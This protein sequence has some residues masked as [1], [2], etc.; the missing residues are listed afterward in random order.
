ML[1]LNADR[2][3]IVRSLLQQLWWKRAIASKHKLA[4]NSAHI[5]QTRPALNVSQLL[6]CN[7]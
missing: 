4:Q 6:R 2:T 7:L 5:D 3:L 1:K